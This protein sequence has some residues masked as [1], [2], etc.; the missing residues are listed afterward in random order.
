MRTPF[1][2]IALRRVGRPSPSKGEV[3]KASDHGAVVDHRD[4][5]RGDLLAELI[6]EEGGV[7]IDGVAVGCLEDVTDQASGHLG[8]EDDW[9][10]LRGDTTR[11]QSPYSATGGLGADGL[12]RF[13]FRESARRRV[14]VVALHLAVFRLRDGDSGDRGVG[15][16]VVADEATGVGKYLASSGG[17]EASSVTVLDAGI[18]GERGGL[19]AA[20]VV[21]ALIAGKRVDVFVV[22]VEILGEL[23]K[24]GCFRESGE[25]VLGGNAGE[26]NGSGDKMFDAFGAQVAGRGAC[27][28]LT[29]EDAKADS[30]G[31]G[32]L[33][34]VDL[35][36]ANESGKFIALANDDFGVGGSGAHGFGDDV[37][38]ELVQVLRVYRCGFGITGGHEPTLGISVWNCKPRC[39]CSTGFEAPNRVSNRR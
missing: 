14:P 8:R 1:S 3:P 12:R 21:D 19:G 37:G 39:V 13:E 18:G 30:T 34:S 23:T 24:G 35:A 2:M 7:A 6:S 36:K 17:V 28:A 38:G 20:G 5:F 25:W 22:K 33:E 11:I 27:G 32:F 10:A 4:V 16:A 9:D 31:S 15:T 29:E 26:S